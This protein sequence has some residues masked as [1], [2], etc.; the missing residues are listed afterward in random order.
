MLLNH[1]TELLR[2]PDGRTALFAGSELVGG[3]LELHG[4]DC[5][6]EFRLEGGLPVWRHTAHGVVFEKRVWMPYDHNTTYVSYTLLDGPESVRLKLRPSVHFRGH[7]EAVSVPLADPYTLTALDDAFEIRDSSPR[8]PLRLRLFGSRAAFTAERVRMREMLYR[9]EENRGY[10]SI[11]DLWCLGYF[12]A[13]LRRD[14]PVTLVASTEPWEAFRDADPA[15]VLVREVE[16][17]RALVARAHP[18]LR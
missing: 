10:D 7:D 18:T 14:E 16:R 12:R 15:A 5:M 13:D 11:G 3:R 9:I 4:V 17:R 8:P 6:V 1:L 2:L